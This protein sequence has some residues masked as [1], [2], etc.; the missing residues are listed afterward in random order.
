[1]ELD[2][3]TAIQAMKKFMEKHAAKEFALQDM[4]AVLYQV[5]YL[6]QNE[7]YS[8]REYANLTL[9]FMLNKLKL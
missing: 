7:E 4:C 6:C 3:D 2:C 8:V 5:V 1:M 9:N